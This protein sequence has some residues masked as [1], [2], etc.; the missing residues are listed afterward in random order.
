[1]GQRLRANLIYCNRRKCHQ[2]ERINANLLDFEIF[3]DYQ[4][5]NYM[6]WDDT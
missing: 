2:T 1:M 6:A 5:V 3:A 4:M